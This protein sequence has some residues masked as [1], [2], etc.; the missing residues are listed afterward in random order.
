M[1]QK[2]E[3]IVRYTEQ[4]LDEML[5]RGEDR[6]NLARLDTEVVEWFRS[7]GPGYQDEPPAGVSTVRPE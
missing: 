7:G 4:E 3:R 2:S 5:R 1:M 6:S